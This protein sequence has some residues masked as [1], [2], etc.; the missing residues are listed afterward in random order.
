MA[1]S[2]LIG[3]VVISTEIVEFSVETEE[4]KSIS[5]IR[6]R[7]RHFIKESFSMNISESSLLYK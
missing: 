6:R 2:S 1:K 3:G 5:Y 4:K 7:R